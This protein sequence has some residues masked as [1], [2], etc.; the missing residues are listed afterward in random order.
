VEG[1]TVSGAPDEARRAATETQV[2]PADSATEVEAEQAEPTPAPAVPVRRGRVSAMLRESAIIVVSAL[3]LSMVIK[4]F[5]VQSFYIPSES[6][7]DTLEVGDRV[8]VTK[9]APGPLDVHRGDVV[10][11]KD[12]G[13][14]LPPASGPER[15]GIGKVAVDALTFVGLLPQDSG[16]HLIKRV[17]GV[18][19]DTVACCDEQGRV[20]VNGVS[21]DEPYLAPGVEPSEIEFSVVVPEDSLWV[22]GDNRQNSQD[23][24]YNQG[25]P[26]GGSIPIGNVVGVAFLT[27]WP[28]DRATVLRNPGDTFAEVP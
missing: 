15:T 25:N 2:E 1:V 8:L 19:G 27:L 24:R 28:P 14:W 5:L 17:I 22:M 6:M 11:F 20:S 16:E 4:T 26:G 10:V 18:P 7:E 9:L 3:V 23:S 13:G 12:P 21:I